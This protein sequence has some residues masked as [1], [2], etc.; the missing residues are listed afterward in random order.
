MSTGIEATRRRLTEKQADTV[1]RLT[2]AAV[3]V[4]AREGYSG[5]SIRLVASAAGVGT[6][7]AYTY[8]SSKEHLISEVYWRRLTAMPVPDMA[9]LDEVPRVIAVLRQVSMLV[10]DEPALAGAVSN[11]LLGDD[12]DVKHLRVRI[13]TEIRSRLATALAAEDRE[14][15]DMLELLYAGALLQGGIGLLSYEQVADLLQACAR[16]LFG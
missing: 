7:T 9:G 14:S 2:V 10:A 1:D 5:T 12:P 13:G 15:L 11:A 4:L 3:E 8:F 16:R 6:A